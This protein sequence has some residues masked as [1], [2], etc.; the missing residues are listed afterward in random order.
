MNTHPWF[1]TFEGNYFNVR[2]VHNFGVFKNSSEAFGLEVGDGDNKWYIHAD[3]QPVSRG[4]ETEEAA[5][6]VLHEFMGNVTIMN[7]NTNFLLEK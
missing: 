1:K 6:L 4:Y 5:R 7:G 3:M 2:K